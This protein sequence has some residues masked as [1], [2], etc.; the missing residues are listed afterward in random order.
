MPVAEK[1]QVFHVIGTTQ[2]MGTCK[3][4]LY[5]DCSQLQKKRVRQFKWGTQD[6]TGAIT[7]EHYDI[8][9]VALRK[10]CK[11]CQRRVKMPDCYETGEAVKLLS[12]LRLDQTFTSPLSL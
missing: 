6:S 5:K 9:Y 4:H 1:V 8:R 11:V 10:I 3:F 2:W 7:E 12:T